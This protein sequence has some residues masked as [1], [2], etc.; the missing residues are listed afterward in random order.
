MLNLVQL[1]HSDFWVLEIIICLTM[2]LKGEVLQLVI[3]IALRY[4][5]AVEGF[6]FTKPVYILKLCLW[7]TKSNIDLDKI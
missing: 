7:W 1:T 3:A 4:P 6:K 2:G 5:S